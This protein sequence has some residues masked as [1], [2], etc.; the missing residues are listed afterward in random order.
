MSQ[1][2]ALERSEQRRPFLGERSLRVLPGQYYDAETGKHYNYFRD[3]DPGI[4]RYIESD[5]IGLPGGIN[6]YLYVEA[7]P[8]VLV[9]FYGLMSNQQ[10][11]DS[12]KEMGQ[13]GKDYGWVI[14]CEGR[15]VSCAFPRE[16]NKNV[17]KIVTQ[18]TTIHED[19]HHPQ[20]PPCTSCSVEP[21]RVTSFSP[22]VSGAAGECFAYAK[23]LRCMKVDKCGKDNE[24]R[25]RIQYLIKFY[26][27]AA[28]AQ[29]RAGMSSE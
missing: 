15:K 16:T 19:E 28:R 20:T 27:G 14:C 6:T 12:S 23:D 11:C 25:K 13:G 24:C 18:C 9:D 5:P 10:C 29:C 3:Y 17:Q 8:A 21:K 7:S 4:G 1:I 2:S 26:G 22:G